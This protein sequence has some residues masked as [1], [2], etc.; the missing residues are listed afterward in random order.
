LEKVRFAP[1]GDQAVLAYLPDESAAVRLAAAVRASNPPWLQDV[2]PAYASVGVFFDAA[3]IGTAEVTAWLDAL[4][5]AANHQSSIINHQFSIPVCYDMAPDMPRVC[6][7][8]GL[9]ADDVIRLHTSTEFTIYAAWGGC[10]ARGCA[11]SRGAWR[12]QAG[13]RRSTRRRAPAAGT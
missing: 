9:T 5:V 2:V 6:E 8:T 11:S 1:L 13:R 10:R 7:H 4:P 12:S 3:R